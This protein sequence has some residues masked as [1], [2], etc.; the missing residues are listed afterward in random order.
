MKGK[1]K[2]LDMHDA[3]EGV[4]MEETK[5]LNMKPCKALSS[6]KQLENKTKLLGKKR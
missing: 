4:E 3:L 1:V 2:F 6:V 5:M